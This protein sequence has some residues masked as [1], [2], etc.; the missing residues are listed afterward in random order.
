MFDAIGHLTQCMIMDDESKN[1]AKEPETDYTKRS[2]TFFQSFEEATL[3][4]LKEMASHTHEERLANLE[5]L[6]RRFF[7]KE[8][9]WKPL[10]RVI[11]IVK[12]TI[13]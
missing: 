7:L 12:G 8:K 1:K 11:T 10:A 2:I 3:H 13:E 6:R 4:G 9:E 5:T